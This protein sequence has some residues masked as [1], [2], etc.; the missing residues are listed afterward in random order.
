M[1]CHVN[2]I[3]LFEGVIKDALDYKSDIYKK[4]HSNM[5]NYGSHMTKIELGVKSTC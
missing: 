1:E 2:L 4:N 3:I 5:F